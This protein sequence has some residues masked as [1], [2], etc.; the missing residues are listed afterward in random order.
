VITETGYR[1]WKDFSIVKSSVISEEITEVSPDIAV[2]RECLADLEKQPRRKHYPFIN[3]THCGPRFSIVRDL[4]YD[5][6]RTSMNEFPMCDPCREE[7][8]DIHDRRF[9]AQPIACL[10][11]GP[12]YE[13]QTGNKTIK[14]TDE[15][16]R[17]LA[18]LL[19][20][21]KIIAFK[22]MGGFH[23]ACSA[24]DEKA[25]ERLRKIKNREGKPFAVMYGSLEELQNVVRISPAEKKSL[26][27]WRRPIVLLKDLPGKENRESVSRGL[28]TTGAMLPYMPIHHL[29]FKEL[30]IPAIVLTSGN[31]SDEPI[32]IDNK[33]A[34]QKLK[35]KAD[36]LVVYNRDIENRT[37]DSVVKIMAGKERVL[38]RSRGYAP[39]PVR[40]GL[41]A[42]GIWA[43]GA[44]LTNCFC[45]GK[46]NLAFLSQHIG[47]LKNQETFDFFTETVGKFERL[48][49]FSPEMA[50]CDLHP[51]YLAT[52]YAEEVSGK[53]KIPL[54]R[55]Q[56]HHAHI[57]SCMAEH[58]LDEKVIGVAMDG[59]GYGDD[60]KIWGAE[61]LVADL[62][63]YERFSHFEY[64]PLPGGDLAIEEPWRM[65]IVWLRKIYGEDYRKLN[66]RFVKNL[67]R[68]KS[69]VIEKMIE[70]G[71]NCPEVSS[72]GRLF[73]AVAAILGIC[74]VA[75]FQAEA[76]MRLE[77]II[78]PGVRDAYPFLPG[79]PVRFG[80]M[81][82]A[83]VH[84]LTRKT[85]PARI[86]ARFHNTVIS[87]IF[88]TVKAMSSAYR[89]DKVV[90][91]GG[92]FQNRY[93]T[94]GILK[95]LTRHGFSV[96]LQ[97]KVPPNDGGLAL[98]QLAIAAKRRTQGCV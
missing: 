59:T 63:G 82:R 61:F 78:E 92:T 4:P 77:S 80:P 79:N 18:R 23:L 28:G 27:G 68:K 26:L 45:I 64:V 17:H 93:L 66:L 71:I 47:D 5:R 12:E 31:L 74:P 30:K 86:S 29:L 9:H 85:G 84:D 90:L 2:C 49:R 97:E 98:G 8:S 50:V 94:E 69:A 53:R 81:I 89:L 7:Y 20:T 44:E 19:E 36:G 24:E 35:G 56:H 58:G 42:E 60:G 32:L 67:D 38:R 72:A 70:T 54:I 73:D 95:K 65:G 76:P 88:E 55:V 21:G 57:A 91:S 40:L 6:N 46:G 83:M 51:Q 15:I 16:V 87:A 62:C 41:N 34:A 52:K 22:G 48:F 14:G 25:V 43:A 33:K 10:D 1:E 13:L 39:S 11:C 96:Y 75:S 3:C 37:D